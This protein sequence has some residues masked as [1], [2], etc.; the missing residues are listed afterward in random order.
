MSVLEDFGP[1]SRNIVIK[2]AWKWAKKQVVLDNVPS[3]R[4][5]TIGSPPS[6]SWQTT[7]KIILVTAV[8]I[9]QK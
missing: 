1:D 8:D 3:I 7:Y 5:K 4:Y 2:I 9:Q 6:S